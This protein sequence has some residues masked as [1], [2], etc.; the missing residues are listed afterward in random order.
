M[1]LNLRASDCIDLRK[2]KDDAASAIARLRRRSGKSPSYRSQRVPAPE[3]IVH[4]IELDVARSDEPYH[5]ESA[6]ANPEQML[7]VQVHTHKSIVYPYPIVSTHL[8]YRTANVLAGVTPLA[9]DEDSACRALGE[10]SGGLE[11]TLREAHTPTSPSRAAG[12]RV[13]ARARSPL[14]S[15]R[16]QQGCLSST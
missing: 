6:S 4:L 14:V 9:P 11:R 15:Q 7:P 5:V 16:S 3:S 2:H 13:K 8:L 1:A 10:G 12:R